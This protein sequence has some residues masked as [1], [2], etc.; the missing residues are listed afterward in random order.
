M[1]I[2]HKVDI[3]GIR[4]CNFKKRIRSKRLSKKRNIIHEKVNILKNDDDQLSNEYI[5]QTSTNKNLWITDILEYIPS[6]FE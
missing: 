5:I 6:V 3:L 1:K 2:N 4:K